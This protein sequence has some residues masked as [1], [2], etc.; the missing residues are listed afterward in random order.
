M[1]VVY[2]FLGYVDYIF[3]GCYQMESLVLVPLFFVY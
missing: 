1:F 2:M 3:L